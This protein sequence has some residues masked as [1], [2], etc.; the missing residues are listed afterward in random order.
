M[1]IQI[2]KASREIAFAVARMKNPETF[3]R[4]MQKTKVSSPEKCWPWMASTDKCGYGCMTVFGKRKSTHRL[5]H[6]LFY[7]AAIG[8]EVRHLCHNPGCVNPLHLRSGTHAENMLDRK[9]ANRGGD[10]RGMA[11]GR[12]KLT[13]E[14]V[15]EIRASNESGASLARRLSVSTVNICA[16]KRGKLW[17]HIN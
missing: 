9:A 16:I 17:T 5:M 14:Q 12:A 6:D 15:R 8:K 2:R 11:N 1:G 10:L 4:L 3:D 7:P 13:D